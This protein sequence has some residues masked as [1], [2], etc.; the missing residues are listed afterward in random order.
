MLGQGLSGSFFVVV[1]AVMAI[2]MEYVTGQVTEDPTLMLATLTVP[3]VALLSLLLVAFANVGTQAVGSYIYAVMLRASFRLAGYRTLLAVLAGYVTLLCLWG[4]VTEY[5]GS[6]LTI[7]ACVYA[8]LAALLFTDFFFVRKQRLDLRS[9]YGMEGHRAYDY[10]G[11]FNWVGLFCVA[12]GIAIS[13]V[14]YDPV[15]A[16]VRCLPLFSLTPTGASFLGTGLL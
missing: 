15:N 12:A 2:A 16:T 4:K 6:F 3:A 9:A 8:P 13:L 7:G 11:G 14:A 10:T 1:G 5:F